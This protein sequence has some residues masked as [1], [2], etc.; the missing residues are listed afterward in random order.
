MSDPNELEGFE[1]EF[2]DEIEC[3]ECGGVGTVETDDQGTI[4]CAECDGSGTIAP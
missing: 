3:P 2:E 4:D 1:A